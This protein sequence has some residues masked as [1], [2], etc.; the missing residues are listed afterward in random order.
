MLETVKVWDIQNR[1][2]ATVCLIY[3]MFP[4]HAL[5]IDSVKSSTLG[6][7]IILQNQ[8]EISFV[9][10]NAV[11]A[12]PTFITYLAQAK[13]VYLVYYLL[14]YLNMALGG[15]DDCNAK[16]SSGTSKEGLLCQFFTFAIDPQV[17]H[18][19]E[20]LKWVSSPYV[21]AELRHLSRLSP[22]SLHQ[23]LHR[24]MLQYLIQ[25]HNHVDSQLDTKNVEF[26]RQC[27]P[28][29]RQINWLTFSNT[30]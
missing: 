12:N 1:H 15:R 10:H 2:P 26:P 16:Y 7:S 22:S 4:Q 6:E 13:P 23:Q 25:A 30:Y 18:L 24:A 9:Y 20:E 5:I 29:C 19:N 11:L 27:L 14:F 17:L 8:L 28:V 3:N 21:L